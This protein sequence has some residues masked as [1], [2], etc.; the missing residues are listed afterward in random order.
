M[1]LGSWGSQ[2]QSPIIP[3]MTVVHIIYLILILSYI[4]SHLITFLVK[5]VHFL[6][7]EEI[8]REIL[9]RKEA[10]LLTV[11]WVVFVVAIAHGWVYKVS[12]VDPRWTSWWLGARNSMLVS[13]I[14]VERWNLLS[15][16]LGRY[17]PQLIGVCFELLP[18]GMALQKEA[19]SSLLFLALQA[20]L[21]NCEW[22]LIWRQCCCL[23]WV[24]N[25]NRETIFHG[26]VGRKTP[27]KRPKFLR[28]IIEP[29][30]LTHF[31]L[32]LL[33]QRVYP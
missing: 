29:I 21:G 19:S 9:A 5:I 13:R 6:L 27:F 25:D 22:R 12:R 20:R 28:E 8:N 32:S 18:L 14:T 33:F 7:G 30:S 24:I 3:R 4:L 2:D 1:D 16:E 26:T 15:R 10:R 17:Q 11:W 23:S 31:M